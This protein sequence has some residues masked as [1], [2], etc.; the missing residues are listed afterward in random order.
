[1]KFGVCVPNYGD[2]S[3]P[4]GLRAVAT[5]AEKLGYDSVWTTDHIL[6]PQRSGTPYERILDSIVSLG[7]LAPLT[8]VLKLGISSLVTPMRNPVV[9]AKQLATLD[10]LSGGRLI[11]VTSAGWNEPEFTHL[12]SNFHDRGKRLDES[13]RLFRELWGGADNFRSELLP[14]SISKAVFQPMPAQRSI[15]IWIGGNSAAAMKRAA[16]LGDG[17]H[18]NALPLDSFRELVSEFR[19]LPNG[20]DKVISVRLQLNP[21]AQASEETSARGNRRLILSGDVAE[22]RRTISELEKLG[23]SYAVIVPNPDGKASVD[24]QIGG[25]R[26]LARE[27]LQ[28]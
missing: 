16:S 8:R 27:F 20:K 14:H 26:M 23:V 12:G 4:E 24:E 5:E 11:L 9:V 17:W 22:N 6:M 2:T 7:Y 1:M 3:S 10:Q 19:N 18:P 25:M 28:N 21:K 15:P 13:I